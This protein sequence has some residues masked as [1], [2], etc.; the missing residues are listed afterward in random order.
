MGTVAIIGCGNMGRAIIEGLATGETNEQIVGV[1]SDSGSLEQL[2]N[3][4]AGHDHVSFVTR[5]EELPEGVTDFIVAVKPKDV[6]TALTDW[7]DAI[8]RAGDD[9]VVISVAAGL[10]LAAIESDV[11][12]DAALV[13]AMPNTPALVGAGVTG[14]WSRDDRACRR[15]DALF[16]AVGEVVVLDSESEFDA[17]T[18]VSGSGPAYVFMAIEALADGGV[19]EGL[20]RETA[21]TLAVQTILGA[22]ELASET[23]EHPGVLKD[24]VTSPGGTTAAGLRSLESDGFRS[25]WIQAVKQ[26]AERSRS[27]GEDDSE[28]N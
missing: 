27:M 18:A 23:G 28:K 6:S 16:S 20:D 11:P 13:R 5:E 26:A 4:F 3:R 2:Q 7:R 9:A 1:T 24:A 22:S 8:D 19:A 15:A 21:V 12:K 25:S 17:L 14:L 10:S